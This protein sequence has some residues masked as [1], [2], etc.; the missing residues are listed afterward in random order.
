MA[1]YE[2]TSPDGGRY[3]VTAPDDASEADVLS[4]AQKQF[5]APRERSMPEQVVRAV[6]RTVRAG[7][8]GVTTIPA[9]LGNAVGLD[10]SGAV[11]RA[12]DVVGLPRPENATE[13]VAED[14]AGGMAGGGGFARLGPV[15]ARAGNEVVKRIGSIFEQKAGTQV[16]S[17]GTGGGAAGVVREEGGG[18]LSQLA[19]GF[20]GALAPSFAAT[21]G[22]TALRGA[23][24]GGEVGRARVADNINTFEDAGAGSPTVG[25]ATESRLAR[26]TESALSKTPGSAGRMVAQAENEAAGVGAK[27]DEMAASVAP[28][29][30]AAPAGRDIKEGIGNFVENFRGNSSRLYDELDRFIPKDTR[31]DV[32]N[33][34]AALEKLNSDIP[35]AP[36]LSAWFK[37][38][39]I[40]GIEAAL[41][42]DISGKGIDPVEQAFIG[43]FEDGRLP[44]EALKKLR[45][46]V[47][48][49]MANN[50]LVSDVPR[51]KWSAL[52]GALS[53]D[54]A[55]AA[56]GAGPQ[57][58][59][60][61][62][63]AN[64]YYRSGVKR[65]DDVL[66]PVLKKG[67]P[68]DIFKAAISGTKEGASTI[69]G[70]MKSLPDES[71]QVVSGT[72]LKR[73]GLAMP[74]KQ[75]ELGE[76]F[77]TE[78]F[79]TNWNKLHPDAKRVLFAPLSD[80]MRSDLDKIARVAANIREGSKVF[81]NPSGTA[82][83][84]ANY[85]TA[86]AALVAA[87]TGQFGVAAGIGGAVATANGAARLMTNPR[88]VRWLAES[89]KAPIEQLPVQLNELAQLGSE[90]GPED[91]AAV[92][93]LLSTARSG[94]RSPAIQ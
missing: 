34:R 88:F 92:K 11:D 51:S 20:A 49:E 67:D 69:S 27:I 19:A 42:K 65:I 44:Y 24:R 54:L 89:T 29:S 74:G 39:K 61:F 35:S 9:A 38:A 85:M 8:K 62:I 2:I 41:K 26:A 21:A 60:S 6:G 25:Q 45:T 66:D 58:E 33:T 14:V 87:L 48:N 68:E 76:V 37:N 72:M 83:A 59:R 47:G 22:A 75:N 17:G 7:V 32:G 36:A 31:V 81:A 90:M 13:R 4:Y 3:E 46:L 63:R 80:E 12:L 53:E 91:R 94:A 56:R 30:G 50:S 15:M 18:P 1:R 52:Y 28:R 84:G 78:T 23:L 40:Q 16:V 77:S 82:Q 55:G 73:L 70:V 71:R 5:S 57:A 10:S 86:G 43:R 64:N 79:L 93:A